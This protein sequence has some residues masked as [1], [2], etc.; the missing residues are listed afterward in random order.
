MSLFKLQPSWPQKVGNTKNKNC[1]CNSLQWKTVLR[2]QTWALCS[3][4]SWRDVG[5][6]CPLLMQWKLSWHQHRRVW[7]AAFRLPQ[8]VKCRLTKE[9]NTDYKSEQLT[10]PRRE[11]RACDGLSTCTPSQLLGIPD[12]LTGIYF[13]CAFQLWSLPIFDTTSTTAALC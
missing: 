1:D 11:Q 9:S 3:W 7:R 10:E 4:R 6:D 13:S 12:H 5:R 2:R 8:M